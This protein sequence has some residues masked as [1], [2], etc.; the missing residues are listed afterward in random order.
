MSKDHK[1]TTQTSVTVYALVEDAKGEALPGT[2]V[3]FTAKI[4]PS[5]LEA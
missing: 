4:E 5:S 2:E 3:N 1:V